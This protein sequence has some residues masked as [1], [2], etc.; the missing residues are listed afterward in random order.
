MQHNRKL[1][2]VQGVSKKSRDVIKN[3]LSLFYTGT[4]RMAGSRGPI[5]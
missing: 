3:L 2:F 1:N 5:V 4:T